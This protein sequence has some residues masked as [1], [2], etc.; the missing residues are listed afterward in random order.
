MKKVFSVVGARPN[1]MKVAPIHRALQEFPDHIEHVIIHTGQHYD[2][3]M[4][5]AFFNDLD[6][7]KPGYFLRVGSASHAVQTAKIMVAF[8]EICIND[9]PDLVIVVGD[10]NSTLACALTARKLGITVVHVEA[11]LRSGDRTMPEELNRLATDA[12]SDYAFTSEPSGIEHLLREGWPEERIKFVGNTMIDSQHY[13]RERAVMSPVMR[14]LDLIDDAY[15]L[16]TLHR[17]SNVDMAEQLESLL[18]ALAT[19]SKEKTVIF[20]AHPRTVARIESFG[21]SHI[22]EQNPQLRIIGA[23]GY[24]R[25]LRLVMGAAF[26]ITDSGGLQ[27]ETTAL[28]LPCLTVRTTTE[29]PI[30]CDLG[31]NQLIEPTAEAILEAS[32][33]LLRG[34]A[35]VGSVPLF[36]DGRAG[37]RIARRIMVI[38]YPE[39]SANSFKHS[40]KS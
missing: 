17:P 11:G 15:I 6:M 37:S 27:E 34:E 30:T 5:D 12:V 4:S 39:L 2:S 18:M 38:L 8:E 21:L 10:V 3:I 40:A 36:W 20:P 33:A 1:F 31:T 32:Q 9:T 7:P 22:L 23:Q 25:F 14:E 19:L 16:V 24:V 35:K 29:R 13:A 28:R 26:V